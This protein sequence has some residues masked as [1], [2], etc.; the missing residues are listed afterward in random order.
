MLE[1][2][3][4]MATDQL[5]SGQ[6]PSLQGAASPGMA[7]TLT[8]EDRKRRSKIGALIGAGIGVL[9]GIAILAGGGL[10]LGPI[11]GA[12]GAVA[13]GAGL[14]ALI[15]YFKR[16]SAPVTVKESDKLIQDRYGQNLQA[17]IV[18]GISAEKS[19]IKV[20]DDAAFK[21]AYQA[22]GMS[23]D[24]YET[25]GGFVDRST[26]PPTV[27]I[28]KERQ[29]TVTVL[30]EAV[31]LYSNPALRHDPTVVATIQAGNMVNEGFTHYFTEQI[32]DEQYLDKSGISTDYGLA[33]K[34]VRALVGLV[35]EETL[36][37]AYFEG[38]VAGLR[39]AFDA[40]HGAGACDAWITA[41]NNRD[42][43]LARRIVKRGPP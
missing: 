17:Q 10:A 4:A 34:E 16:R 26:N 1:G 3:A 20:V 18:A 39:T 31:H 24:R 8:K 33:A 14:G 37:R 42:W 28:H 12:L 41:M 19:N 40:K 11:L 30:H 21:A 15:G 2:E 38:D 9:G 22:N 23:M 5:A 43:T 27:W 7:L 35:G 32:A 36:R 25:V 29:K 6:A 13:G